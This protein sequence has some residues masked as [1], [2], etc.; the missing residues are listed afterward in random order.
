MDDKNTE[1]LVWFG[2]EVKA[3]GEGKIGGYLVRFSDASTPDLEGDYFDAETDFGELKTS[4]VYYQHGLDRSLKTRRLGSATLKTDEFGVWAETQ[5]EMRDEYEKFIY[6]MAE[7]GKMGWSSGTASH[8]V[9]REPVGKAWH[10][11]H[12]PLGI[13]ASLTPTPAEPRNAAIPL[14]SLKS[15]EEAEVVEGSEMDE[16]TSA[17]EVQIKD[18]AIEQPTPIIEPVKALEDSQMSD[19]IVTPEP[20]EEVSELRGQVDAMSEKLDSFLKAIQ[21]SPKL[22]RGGYYTNDGGEADASHKSFG[23]W[24]LAVKRGDT[25]RLAK[26]YGSVKDLGKDTGS[27][28]GYLVPEEFSNQLLQ[29]AAQASPVAQRVMR[30][31]VNVNSGSY[32]ALD[33]SVSPTA[34]SG[35]SALAAGLSAATTE[36]N[37]A[38]TED[39]PVFRELNWRLHKI[40]GFTEASNEL[41]SDSPQAIEALLTNLFS[42]TIANKNERNIIRGSGAGE[43]LGILNAAC[44]VGVATASD[45]VFAEADALNM[46]SRFKRLSAQQPVWIMHPGV[47][48]DLNGFTSVTSVDMVTYGGGDGPG[49]SGTLLGYPVI[50]SEHMPQDD[51][52]DVILADLGAYLWFQKGALEIAFSE[53]ASFTSDRGVWRFTQ[54]ND[55]M[56]WLSA[57]ITLADPTG[58]Y[59]VSPFVFHND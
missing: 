44:T 41:I 9:E 25:Q 35:Q 42:I 2:D 1:T 36:E 26:V 16:A 49:V 6:E 34:G 46:L 23:D 50:Y 37:A 13:D 22:E 30:V 51:N 53:H 11:K 47:I 28:G 3:L 55:G 59:T 4:P 56:P 39:E 24:L 15:S 52:D 43:P 33:Y 5:L 57:A 19:E 7:A 40:G 10:I 31:P 14:K 45:N 27:A 32:P 54:R 21:E 58:S 29:I 8:L 38:L 20:N 17:D 48:P 12:W 18:V